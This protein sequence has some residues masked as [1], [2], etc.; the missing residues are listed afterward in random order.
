MGSAKG[1][2]IYYARLQGHQAVGTEASFDVVNKVNE[3]IPG[4]LEYV[5]NSDYVSHFDT[6]R[7]DFIFMEH[8]M[9]H[10]PNGPEFIEQ[11]KV[12]LNPGGVIFC[13]VPNHASYA[14]IK[15][16]VNWMAYDPPWHL[17]YYTPETLTQIFETRGF[18]KMHLYTNSTYHR[19]IW[20]YY[21]WYTFFD[22]YITRIN[23]KF[24]L[25]LPLLNPRIDRKPNRLIFDWICLLPYYILRLK[26]AL[27]G[28]EYG[29]EI[30]AF[31]KKLEV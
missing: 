27:S 29:E 6:R 28:N 20:L 11:L 12:L 13:A 7:F 10:L 26:A 19:M 21:S 9:E 30:N 31:Y 24:S 3:A 1:T 18:T 5:E 2:F 8:V 14:S 22:K 25:K 23:R 15:Q 4:L 16:G 17:M